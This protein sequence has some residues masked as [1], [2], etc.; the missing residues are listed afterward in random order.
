LETATATQLQALD[1]T[2]TAKR[3]A[4]EARVTSKYNAD[5][6]RCI[7]AARS[8]ERKV[9]DLQNDMNK[10]LGLNHD[11][12]KKSVEQGIDGVRKALVSTVQKMDGQQKTTIKNINDALAARDQAITSLGDSIQTVKDETHKAIA[13]N[14]KVVESNNATIARAMSDVVSTV[15]K[16]VAG[17]RNDLR[18][19]IGAVAATND[20]KRKEYDES[21]TQL[22]TA[23]KAVAD[24][25][26]AA[27]DGAKKALA[28]SSKFAGVWPRLDAAERECAKTHALAMSAVGQ[29]NSAAGD[30]RAAAGDARAAAAE[31]VDSFVKASAAEASHQRP[32]ER[33]ATLGKAVTGLAKQAKRLAEDARAADKD[34]AATHAL[35]VAA[36]GD[37]KAAASEARAAAAESRAAAGN[38]VDAFSQAA[39]ADA[40]RPS[41]AALARVD[42]LQRAV[43]A[44]SDD[45]ATLRRLDGGPLSPGSRS[46][47]ASLKEDVAAASAMTQTAMTVLESTADDLRDRVAKV[48]SG[49]AVTDSRLARCESSV[50]SLS[51]SYARIASVID[52]LRRETPDA[53]HAAARRAASPSRGADARVEELLAERALTIGA[54][55]DL[56]RALDRPAAEI[57]PLSVT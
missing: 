21:I 19:E 52:R 26:Q 15:E 28:E 34:R 4:L 36:Q 57:D 44:L 49:T 40:M 41:T 39:V 56:A 25:S 6:D 7:E 27:K 8:A 23:M 10:K 3:E 17:V 53:R 54:I 48:V 46:D 31:A 37:A 29:A 51:R 11:I 18:D 9:D 55:E 20:A 43:D 24:R 47:V 33:L 42:Q 30:A 14:N 16:Q 38:A 12:V 45:V 32:D 50:S 2:C 5:A 13:A 1:A 35:A 22:T